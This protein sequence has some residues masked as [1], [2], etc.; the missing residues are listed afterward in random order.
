MPAVINYGGAL[1]PN[2]EVQAMYYGSDWASSQYLGEAMQLNRFLSTIVNSSYMDMLTKAGYGVGRGTVAPGDLNAVNLDRTQPLSDDQIQKALDS[3]ITHGRLQ[4]PDANRLYVVFVEDN[5]VVK[6]SNGST[7]VSDFVGYHGDANVYYNGGL[8]GISGFFTYH[9]AVVTYPGGNISNASW[10]LRSAFDDMTEA[11][12][13]EL[14]EAVTD[15]DGGYKTRGWYDNNPQ[16]QPGEG[17]VG[18]ICN[19][20][21]VYLNGYA[22]QRIADQNDQAMTPMGATSVYPVNF[23]LTRDGNVYMDSSAGLTFVESNIAWIS[24][25]GVDNSGHAMIDMVTPD[26]RVFE[27]HERLDSPRGVEIFLTSNVKMAKAGQGVSYV[28]FTNGELAEY[29]DGGNWYN[30]DHK[31][32]SIDAGTD[33]YG[34]NMVTEVRTDTFRA[35]FWV[36]GQPISYYRQ[37]SDGYER[38]DSTGL[39]FIASNVSSMSAGQQ[40]FMDYVTTSGDAW[41]YSESTAFDSY[42]GSGV[43]AVTAGTDQNGN[44]MI[45]LLYSSGALYEWRQGRGLTFLDNNVAKIGKAHVG[46]VDL[47]F[48]WGSAWAYDAHSW[49]FLANYVYMDS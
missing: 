27:Y 25:Q 43:A 7:S 20:Q 48:S 2:V 16:F 3:E 34:V 9:Y 42:L 38:S 14:A 44:Y 13:H 15:P 21:A 49:Q 46:V 39:H 22:V 31:V 12:S 18:D 10:G 11:A 6:Q 5:V 33:Q 23:F 35:I 24:D 28:L 41:W 1:L 29:K 4:W 45:D 37:V 26:G 36:N 32:Q 40:G 17:E 19:A 8:N 30:L 47:V